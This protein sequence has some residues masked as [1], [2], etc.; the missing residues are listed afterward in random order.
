LHGLLRVRGFTQDDAH[1][2]VTPDKLEEEI[3]TVLQFVT[4]IFKTFGFHEYEIYLSTRP[5]KSVGS[6]EDWEK[7]TRA[8]RQALEKTKLSYAVETG[9]GVFYGPKIDI[10][11]KDSLGRAWQCSTIQVDFNLPARFHLEFV[12]RDGTKRPPIMVHRALLGSMERFFGCLVE[13]YAGQFPFWLS[14]VQATVLPITDLEHPFADEICKQLKAEGFRVE[15]DRRNEKLG[16]KI[17]EAQIHKIPYMLVVGHEES[18]KRAV[19]VRLRTGDQLPNQTVEE[20][21]RMFKTEEKEHR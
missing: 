16:F 6:D 10:K 13:H 15:V 11:V 20:L 4:R 3:L 1:I 14:P 18:E 19:N 12:D 8:L 21:V 9:E 17:R 2:F 7:A 5:A